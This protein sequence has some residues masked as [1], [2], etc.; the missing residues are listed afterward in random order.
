MLG[1][2][3]NEPTVAHDACRR[4]LEHGLILLPSGDAG[5]VLSLTPPLC[6]DEDVLLRA[7]DLLRELIDEASR[8]VTAS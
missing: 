3:C 5:R 4:A 6:I 2:E 7:I 1:I 8:E